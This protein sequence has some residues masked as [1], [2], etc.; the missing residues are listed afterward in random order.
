ME[1]YLKDTFILNLGRN[2]GSTIYKGIFDLL[3]LLIN[4]YLMKK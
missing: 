2:P 3:F 4:K 1:N